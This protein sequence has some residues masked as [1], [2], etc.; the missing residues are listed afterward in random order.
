MRPSKTMTKGYPSNV[1]GWKRR[2]FFISEDNWEFSPS[3]SRE[4]GVLRVPRSWGTPGPFGS[5]SSSSSKS[6]AWSGLWLSLELRSDA[7]SMRLNLKKLAKRMEGSKDASSAVRSSLAA[8]G[9]TIGEKCPRDEMLGVV[10]SK[11]GKSTSDAKGKG[12]TSPPEAK[13]KA[14]WKFITPPNKED[15]KAVSIV[16]VGRGT[17]ANPVAP[18]G[19]KA[20]MLRSS[21]MAEKLLESV[22]PPFDKE[23]LWSDLSSPV[24]VA[25]KR[26][27]VTLQQGWAASLEGEMDLAQNLAMELDKQLAEFKVQEQQN[28]EELTKAKDD[29][30]AI[31]E[32]LAKLEVVVTKLRSN[33][34]HSKRLAIEEFKSLDDS[35]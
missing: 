8:K 9:I 33:E 4:E 20:T 32:K 11:K 30:E 16:A 10:P 14:M 28:A 19:P 6:D 27:K 22:I 34:P 17:S 26:D 18:F 25:K 3:I 1:K 29:R 21:A 13:K 31:V 2:F 35:K 7:M 5:S 24:V 23:K 12:T 15:D